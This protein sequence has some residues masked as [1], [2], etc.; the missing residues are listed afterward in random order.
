MDPPKF[1]GCAVRAKVEEESH[2]IGGLKSKG[3]VEMIRDRILK[4]TS[5]ALIMLKGVRK[6]NL[7]YCQGCEHLYL[8]MGHI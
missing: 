8:E 6:N 3:L 1:S 7:Y 5:G 4:A 2:P